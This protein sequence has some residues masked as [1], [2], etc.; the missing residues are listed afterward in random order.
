MQN[1]FPKKRS[2][3]VNRAMDLDM[4]DNTICNDV[5]VLCKPKSDF[6]NLSK[7]KYVKIARKLEARK[8]RESKKTGRTSTLKN[9]SGRMW[10]E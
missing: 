7:L 3:L 6:I 10:W 5:L 9:G 2:M 1:L 8:R 4:E